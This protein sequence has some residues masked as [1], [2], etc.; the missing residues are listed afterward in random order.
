MK[1]MSRQILTAAVALAAILTAPLAAA[2]AAPRDDRLL[3]AAL[4]PTDDYTI[5]A[6]WQGVWEITERLVDCQTS[7]V[8]ATE[9]YTDTLCAGEAY[10]VPGDSPCTGTVDD[11]SVDITC[12]SSFEAFPGCTVTFTYTMTGTRTGDSYSGSD[13]MVW[14]YSGDCPLPDSCERYE[15]EAT[16][17][18][19]DPACTPTANGQ[20]SW[21]AVK[22]AYR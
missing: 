16:R 20:A 9:T 17:L 5:P 3:R 14:D 22:Q 21:T 1:T 15:W 13:Q 12:T 2:E 19:L 18:A 8:L 4:Q 7:A 11:D 10:L 6:G